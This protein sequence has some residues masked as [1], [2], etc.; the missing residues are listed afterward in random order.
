MKLFKTIILSTVEPPEDTRENSLWLYPDTNGFTLSCYTKGE[1]GNILTNV[2]EDAIAEAISQYIA[3]SGKV[4]STNDF[5]DAYK[6]LIDKLADEYNI[7]HTVNSLGLYKIE[8]DVHGNVSSASPVVKDDITALGIPSENTV[9]SKATQSADGLMSAVDKAKLDNISGSI[10]TKTSDLTNDSGFITKEVTDLTGYYDKSTVDTKIQNVSAA[11][12]TVDDALSTTSANAVKNSVITAA[13]NNKVDKVAGKNLSTNDFTTALKDKLDSL[14]NTSYSPATESAD[15]LMSSTDKTKLD[16]IEEGAQKNTVSAADITAVNTALDLKVDKITGKGL[17]TNDYTDAEKTKLASLSDAQA[18]T[19]KVYYAVYGTTTSAQLETAYQSGMVILCI[20]SDYGTFYLNRRYS[21][22]LFTFVTYYNEYLKTITCNSDAWSFDDGFRVRWDNTLATVTSSG[23]MSAADKTKLVSIDEGAQVN[24]INSITVNGTAVPVDNKTAAIT[25]TTDAI[26]QAV[27]GTTTASEIYTAVTAGKNVLCLYNNMVLVLDRSTSTYAEFFTI[28]DGYHKIYQVSGSTWTNA[29]NYP[30]SYSNATTTNAGL[31]SSTDKIKLDGV[32]AGAQVNVLEG[33]TVN[34]TD[35]TIASKKIS[36]T[37][38]SYSLATTS[39]NGL[40]PQL[41][42]STS[43]Y[44]NANGA[45]TVPPNTTY[46]TATTSS[47][48]LVPILKG[49]SS[50]YL[51]GNGSWSIPPDTNTT[52]SSATTSSAGLMPSLYGNS[53]YYLNGNGQ[54]SVPPDTNT[55]YSIATYSKSGL[56]PSLNNNSSYYLDGSGN[57]SIPK[58]NTTDT[59]TT[60]SV[61]TSGSTVTLTGSDGSSSSGDIQT[62]SLSSWFNHL[63][64][65]KVVNG[66]TTQIGSTIIIPADVS[67]MDSDK[68]VQTIRT[69]SGNHASFNDIQTSH[70]WPFVPVVGSGG[71]MEIGKFLD[72]SYTTGSTNDYDARI[73]MYNSSTLRM[74]A[75]NDSTLNVQITG[76]LTQNAT[77]DRKYKSNVISIDSALDRIDK[78]RPVNFNWNEDAVKMNGSYNTTDLHAGLIA[79]EVA[80]VIPHLVHYQGE[81]YALNYDEIIPYLVSGVKELHTEVEALKAEVEE[82]K[83]LIKQ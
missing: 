74:Q 57:W 12:Y 80:E 72:F 54:W 32:A 62:Y 45:W 23:L 19:S 61:S 75:V 42:G 83:S 63:S 8:T 51:N 13:L 5:T 40:M 28:F 4:L 65:N 56:M 59:N 27:Y 67:G 46:S 6:T 21:A 31:M 22:T 37:I 50:Y 16:N 35:A 36:L 66:I 64:F 39:S 25:V 10:P 38:P 11:G 41:T 14:S 55:T 47:A 1:W 71:Q 2:S 3:D 34:G 52:Y 78:L 48:G 15:G 43:Y 18:S 82:L 76:A 49:S 20:Y 70:P 60:Y 7:V 30:L 69:T 53:S 77:S 81:Y 29:S 33:L 44:L 73:W 79:Q 26:Y 58:G 24:T 9:Y 68:Y 17:S